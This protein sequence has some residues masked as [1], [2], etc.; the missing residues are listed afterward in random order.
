LQQLGQQLL[1]LQVVLAAALQEAFHLLLYCR[2]YL[3]RQCPL[4]A[5][6]LVR[7]ASTG[8]QARLA[9]LHLAAAAC[10]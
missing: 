4:L 9:Q 3:A 10:M 8:V 1:V 6:Q 5:L 7:Q 2:L